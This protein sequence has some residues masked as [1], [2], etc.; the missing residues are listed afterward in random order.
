L[1]GIGQE[2]ESTMKRVILEWGFIL[3]AGVFL[4]L[5]TLWGVSFGVGRSSYHFNVSNPRSSRDDLHILVGRGTLSFC[6]QVDFDASSNIQP[7]VV[8]RRTHVAPKIRRMGQCTLPG[9][10]LR[11][12]QFAPDGYV[13]WS[14]RLSLLIPVVLSLLGAALFYRRRNGHVVAPN[15]GPYDAID[16]RPGP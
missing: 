14:L 5:L 12:C 8:D 4:A 15:R 11:Y 7:W 6:D 2:W 13:V 3:S 16:R 9:F 1:K 10:D